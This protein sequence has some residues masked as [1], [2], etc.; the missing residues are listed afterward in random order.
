[1]LLQAAFCLK[2]LKLVHGTPCCFP[3]SAD[4]FAGTAGDSDFTPVRDAR[5]KATE[6][7][8]KQTK[9]DR[10]RQRFRACQGGGPSR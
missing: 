9:N 6:E 8:D 10:H 7:Q 4:S 2:Q 5:L 3:R 1:M